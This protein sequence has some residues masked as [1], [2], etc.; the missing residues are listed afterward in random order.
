MVKI[1]QK[2]EEMLNTNREFQAS[3]SNQALKKDES[4]ELI[5]NYVNKTKKI[6]R[7]FSEEI[8]NS[9]SRQSTPIFCLAKMRKENDYNRARIIDYAYEQTGKGVKELRVFFVDYG[10]YDWVCQKNFHFVLDTA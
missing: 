8:L 10:D 2:E 9:L 1:T 7:L 5:E 6:Q 3:N 4:E